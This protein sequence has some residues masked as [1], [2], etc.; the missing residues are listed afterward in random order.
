MNKPGAGATIANR[1]IHDAKPDGYTIGMGSIAVVINKLQGML[2]YDY[3]DYTILGA[4]LNAVPTVVAATKTKRPFKTI[5]EIISF[6][7]LHPKE[8]SVACTQKGGPWWVAAME[9][10]SITGAKFNMIPQ[11]GAGGIAVTQVAGGHTDFGIVGLAESKSQIDAGNVRFLA[12]FGDKRPFTY[13]NVPTLKELGYDVKVSSLCVA[14]GPPNMPKEIT[15][16]LVKAVEIVAKDPDYRKFLEERNNT[17]SLYLNPEG[18]VKRYD[19]QREV[20]R[21]I[22]S[23][24]GILKEK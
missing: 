3:H 17:I 10:Q 21:D 16:K 23:K 6:A 2:P 20:F 1:E 4:F 22:L 18:A 13:P 5:P 12:T 19:D 9:F 14:M 24:A 15:D 7:K 11:E 8:V